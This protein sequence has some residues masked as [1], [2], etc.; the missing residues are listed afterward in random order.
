MDGD[1]P[2]ADTNKP[3][4]TKKPTE[5]VATAENPTA[6]TEIIALLRL[7]TKQPPR[8]HDFRTCAICKR[9]GIT[10]I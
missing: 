2:I 3:Q 4:P 8:E 9:Y 7:L 5:D 10:E 1:C 6:S